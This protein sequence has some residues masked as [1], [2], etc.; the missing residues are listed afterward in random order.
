MGRQKRACCG[1]TLWLA[2]CWLA[3]GWP[4]FGGPGAAGDDVRPILVL[5]SE[6]SQSRLE[7]E[8]IEG[9]RSALSP[10]T[11][12]I[13]DYLDVKRMSYSR[14]YLERYDTILYGKYKN[15][16]PAVVVA[17]ND[18]AIRVLG[19]Y[20]TNVFNGLPLVVC[21]SRPQTAKQNLKTSGW[22]GVYSWPDLAQ[23]IDLALCLHP[24]AKAVH[25]LADYT[26][27]G[28][29]VRM[30][31][32]KAQAAGRFPVPVMLPGMDKDQSRPWG[33]REVEQ[34]IRAL[35]PEDVVLYTEYLSD[36]RG[37]VY[38]SRRLMPGLSSASKA[39]IYTTQTDGIGDGA[40]GG[41]VVNGRLMGRTAGEMVRRLLAGEAPGAI[42]AVML[43]G[44]W[45][46]D[47]RQ[48]KRWGIEADDLPEGSRILNRPFAFVRE[49]KWLIL[50]GG[51]I[52]LTE[53][54]IIA[55]LLM[56]RAR[57]RRA[58]R[59]LAASETRY[60]LLYETSRDVFTIVDRNGL[61][62]HTNP[63]ASRMLG[64][65][66]SQWSEVG[67]WQVIAPEDREK[68]AAR[69]AAAIAGV[70][71]SLETAYVTR[72]GERLPVELQ[73]QSCD[74]GGQTTAVC[75]GHLLSEKIKLQAVAQEISE[76]ERQALGHDIH[77]GLGQYVT[78]LRFQIHL[79]EQSTAA[80]RMPSVDLPA[81]LAGIV[82]DLASEV[83]S[84]ARSLVPLHMAHQTLQAALRENADVLQRLFRVAAALDFEL[85]EHRIPGDAAPHLYRLAQEAA[86][87]AVRHGNAKTVRIAVRSLTADTGELVVEND[88]SPFA[89]SPVRRAGLGLSIMEQRARMIGG[90]LVIQAGAAQGTRVSCRF[91]LEPSGANP[92]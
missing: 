22:T 19:H 61:V 60:R 50:G 68:G 8:Q 73:F 35:S 51:A 15:R 55:Q 21:G 45:L 23:T 70:P 27:S 75:C 92:R 17:L 49:Y 84:L 64:Y 48:L 59:A 24:S 6:D 28:Q 62:L 67:L 91:P 41:H 74:F 10:Q 81:K 78:A 82:A 1:K 37:G 9:L 89:R 44:E 57:R 56:S 87:N 14:T 29:R 76:R 18:D 77:D 12:I 85:D 71:G 25:V 54:I 34:Y 79:L 40:I 33:L 88:G 53:S 3:S 36:L 58:Q 39:P 80:G 20:R 69:V 16:R 90:T 38:L 31:I 83:R 11:E 52:I 47:Y 32:S 7:T 86:R 63:A 5:A 2:C 4:A 43:P 30:Q 42:A 72:A 65:A 46:F 26:I 13:V 66:A